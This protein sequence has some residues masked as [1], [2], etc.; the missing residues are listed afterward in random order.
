MD[1]RACS[2]IGHLLT[3]KEVPRTD[4]LGL[5]APCLVISLKG[6]VPMGSIDEGLEP[7]TFWAALGG[8]ADYPK[9]KVGPPSINHR[10]RQWAR[11]AEDGD[12]W[13]V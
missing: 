2:D 12:H 6:A 8:K 4:A 3:T 13:A 9:L 1:K 5:P 7:D 11:E 10:A